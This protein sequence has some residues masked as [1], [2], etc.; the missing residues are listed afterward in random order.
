LWLETK[1]KCG[2][3]LTDVN[4]TEIGGFIH[5]TFWFDVLYLLYPTHSRM[6]FSAPL[7]CHVK[8]PS[9]RYVPLAFFFVLRFSTSFD[10]SCAPFLG[11]FI[12]LWKKYYQ[13]RCVCPSVCMEQLASHLTEFCMEFDIS[14]F[15]E[16]MSRKFQI[17]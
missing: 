6:P 4:M 14:E 12:Q 15:S 1:A 5:C 17:H 8:R 13:L 7:D 11:G 10:Y 16:Y 9:R 2:S 3:T